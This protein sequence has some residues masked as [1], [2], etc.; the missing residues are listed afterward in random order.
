[1]IMYVYIH[2]VKKLDYQ[3]IGA[4]KGFKNSTVSS[5]VRWGV[6][7]VRVSA[8]TLSLDDHWTS[9]SPWPRSVKPMRKHVLDLQRR[10]TGAKRKPVLQINRPNNLSFDTNLWVILNML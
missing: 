4:P 7:C 6:K 9:L 10:G 3:Q 8:R 2:F 1:M 5:E